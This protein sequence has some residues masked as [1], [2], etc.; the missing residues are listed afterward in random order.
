MIHTNKR[1]IRIALL[2]LTMMIMAP[3]AI[4]PII[5]NM[6]KAFPATQVTTIQF[7]LTYP[8]II[9]I[10]VTLIM[11]KI[12][13][14][15]SKKVLAC[16]GTLLIALTG[17]GAYLFH[18]SVTTLYLWATILGVGIGMTHTNAIS[19]IADYF[20]GPER[21]TMMGLQSASGNVGAMLMTLTGGAIAATAWQANYLVYLLALA[22]FF[23]CL[24]FVPTKN[25]T[26]SEP[27]Q[28]DSPKK[29]T[30]DPAVIYYVAIT[31]VF[32]ALFNVSPVNFSLI[33]TERALGGTGFTG[34]VSGVFNVAGILS[35]LLFGMI[36]NKLKNLTIASGYALL[37]IGYFI[38]ALSSGAPMLLIGAF[39]SGCSVCIVMSKI[40]FN[41]TTISKPSTIAMAVALITASTNLGS[42]V[43]PLFTAVAQAIFH[44][45]AAEYRFLLSGIIALVGTLV[46]S[47]S[48]K[49]RKSS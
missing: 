8:C 49:V 46:V 9:V 44:N 32:L 48:E 20:E 11:G 21:G 43:A 17:I 3:T 14:F 10:I 24:F 33:V 40:Y 30:L 41:V 25:P 26:T 15:T 39:I 31:I 45:G 29:G 42:F 23:T 47:V 13:T 6:I 1:G 34:M 2:C 5:A 19:L 35:G 27:V 12:S 37:C 28:S 38:I 16:I 22:G 7:L 36:S 4:S 18:S